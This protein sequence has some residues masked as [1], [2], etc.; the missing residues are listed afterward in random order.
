MAMVIIIAISWTG[1]FSFS[2]G[3]KR[4]SMPSVSDRGEV[5]SVRIWLAIIRN[6]SRSDILTASS[7]PRSVI[8][9]PP[10]PPVN[11]LIRKVSVTMKVMERS[12]FSRKSTGILLMAMTAVR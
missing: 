7:S 12:A 10:P 1:N 8:R 2:K 4:L 5:V 9:K 11:R 6:I 3:R